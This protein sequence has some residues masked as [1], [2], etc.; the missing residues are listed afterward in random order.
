VDLSWA[1]FSTL[2]PSAPGLL[3]VNVYVIDTSNQY[4]YRLR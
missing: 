1:A 2:E 3:R 4:N